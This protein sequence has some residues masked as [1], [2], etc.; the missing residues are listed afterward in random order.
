MLRLI[1]DLSE[2]ITFYFLFVLRLGSSCDITNE[3]R[4]G[5]SGFIRNVF[6]DTFI[7]LTARMETQVSLQLLRT[8]TKF[9]AVVHFVTR[10]AQ[11]LLLSEFIS[12]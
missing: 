6:T 3:T 7:N 12:L 11:I 8:F 9:V 1:H 4:L 5:N 2:N 10:C